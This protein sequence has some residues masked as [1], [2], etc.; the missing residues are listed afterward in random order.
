M[1]TLIQQLGGLVLGSVPTMIL[2]LLTL[3]AYRVLVHTPLT[4]VLKERYSLTQGAIEKASQAIQAAEAKTEEYEHRMRAARSA[5]FRQR[6]ERLHAIHVESEEA[7]SEARAAA[8]QK[9]ATALMSIEESARQARLQ[10]D[11]YIDE[12]TADA[13]RAILPGNNGRAQEQAG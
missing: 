8:Q 5:I 10:L 2:F 13:L 7:L 6:H 11:G 4:R 1:S 3:A 9:T 12:L